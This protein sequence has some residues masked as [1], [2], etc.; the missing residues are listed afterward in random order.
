MP[1]AKSR[2]ASR[3]CC[4][5]QRRLSISEANALR[6]RT[7]LSAATTVNRPELHRSIEIVH[8]FGVSQGPR[9]SGAIALCIESLGPR[10]GSFERHLRLFS[11][12]FH[13]T[14]RRLPIAS[15]PLDCPCQPVVLARQVLGLRVRVR[16][17]QFLR[18]LAVLRRRHAK[19]PIP[20]E[21]RRRLGVLCLRR[22]LHS[23][24]P[25]P[26]PRRRQAGR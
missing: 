13:R 5:H 25:S 20:G 16:L 12:P 23:V 17:A 15:P 7:S 2:V 1:I 9:A 14:G 4:S 3:D 18:R 6:G 11:G 24:A 26:P 8:S 19:R 21:L 22:V 10:Q